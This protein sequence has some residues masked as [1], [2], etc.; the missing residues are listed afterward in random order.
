MDDTSP[1]P[2]ITDPVGRYWDQPPRDDIEI[3]ATH[4]LMTEITFKQLC[5][6]SSTF[7]SGVYP[8]KM[9]RRHDGSNDPRIPLHKRRW[10]LCWY[11]EDVGGKCEIWFREVL[12]A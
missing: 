3:D 12:L 4:A 8:G 9:W 10:L 7:P 1:I 11:G 5:E 2:A 6:Y